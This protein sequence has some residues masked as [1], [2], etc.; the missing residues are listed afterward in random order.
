MYEYIASFERWKK[1]NPEYIEKYKKISSFV[2][3]CQSECYNSNNNISDCIDACK[4]PLVDIERYNVSMIKRLSVDVYETCSSKIEMDKNSN[5][6]T[7]INKMKVCCDNLFSENEIT[8]KN[9][10]LER[11]DSIAKFLN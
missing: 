9:E 7:E 11:L 8:V 6:T 10:T 5:I 4:K 1:I 2:T 3:K